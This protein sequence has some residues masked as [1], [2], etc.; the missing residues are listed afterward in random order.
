MLILLILQASFV[1]PPF[2]YA[3]LMTR[4]RVASAVPMRHLVRALVPFVAAQ[5]A[6]LA[7]VAAFPRILWRDEAP[8][9][10][11]PAPADDDALRRMLEE[12]EDKPQK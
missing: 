4:S 6:V 5:I 8:A 3:V 10:T 7:L 12:S 1:I 2:G 11:T 9:V